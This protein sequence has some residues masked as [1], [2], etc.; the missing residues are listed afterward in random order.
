MLTFERES[1]QDKELRPAL[2]VFLQWANKLEKRVAG[3]MLAT[4]GEVPRQDQSPAHLG[5]LNKGTSLFPLSP[6]ISTQGVIRS[7]LKDPV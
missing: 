3:K 6:Q 4:V 7:D 2:G 5:F 1:E